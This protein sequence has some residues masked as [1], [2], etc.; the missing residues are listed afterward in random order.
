MEGAVDQAIFLAKLDIP[1]AIIG[2]AGTGK[3]YVA[4]IIHE[5]S[6]GATDMLVPIDCRE[7]RS[8]SA[9]N[10]RIAR[11]LA[12]GEGKTLVFKSP[13]LMNAE[14]QLKL[15]ARSVRARWRM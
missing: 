4:R 8:R 9:A 2:P 13:H 11:E 7:F 12:Q 14:V 10:T 1:V 3:M 15:A 6:G 5:E